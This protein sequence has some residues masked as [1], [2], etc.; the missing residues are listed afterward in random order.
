MATETPAAPAK[1]ASQY[2][3]TNPFPGKLTVNRSLCGEG[4]E[5]DTRHFEIDLTGWGLNYE[6]G[7]SMTVWPTNDPK[8]VDEI[9]KAICASGEEKVKSPK[10]TETTLREALFRD[11]RITQTTPKF[12]KMISE[13]ASAAPLI[14]ELL[15]PQRKEDL[16]RYLWGMEVIDFLTEHPSIKISA[17][18]FI[19]TLAKLQPRLYS[20]ASSLNAHPNQVHFTIDVVRYTSHGRQRGGVCSTFL[21]D[22]AENGPVPVFPNASKFRLP[23][24]GNTPIIMVGPGTGIAPFR[25]Y[26]QERQT[27]G[28]KGKNWLFF[29]SQKAACNYFYR[30]EFE[31][32][33]KD[34]FLTHLSLAWSRDQT[35]KVYVQ[36]R[37]IENAAE[38][39][40]WMDGEGAHFFVCG[41]AR[42]MA[43]D[44]D[45]ALRKIVQEQG[46]KDI[47]AANEYVEK[48]K[49]DKRYKRDVY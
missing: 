3:R 12:L 49:S 31:S 24:D 25:A 26:L 36:D 18:E 32:M 45:A 21:A 1:P 38:I 15:D 20:I 34:G 16:D 47:D 8:L 5:K 41:D 27:T 35:Q 39:W 30:D 13:R 2:T 11:C 33:Q 7:D 9:L 19:D 22:R 29:G 17:Q 28:A 40:K 48:L 46:G 6:V 43:K 14:T 42:R 10:G 23:E 4:S 44:V 37:M